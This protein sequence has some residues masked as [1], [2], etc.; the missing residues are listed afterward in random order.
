MPYK[1]LITGATGLIGRK[2]IKLLAGNG[3][4]ITAVTRNSIKARPLFPGNVKLIEWDYKSVSEELIHSIQECGAVIHLAGENVLSKRWNTNHKEKIYS[5]RVGSTRLIAELILKLN[6]KPE[7]FISASAVG[8]YGLKTELP[9]DETAPCGTD[10]LARLT[11][12]WEDATL[13]LEQAGIRCVKIRT[14]IVLDRN[15]GAFA[16]MILPFKFFAGGPL[17][18]GKQFFPWVH[19]EDIAGI[20]I[21]ALNNPLMS[22]V[23]NGAAPETI[24]MKDFCIIIGKRMKRPS[25]F[26]V[27][28]FALKALYGQGAEILLN[29]VNVIPRRT[30]ESGYKF[31]FVNSKEAVESLL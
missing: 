18:N 1:I 7:V 27:P 2:I 14:G 21:H 16:K 25:F 30:L 17:G 29:G 26:N 3:N 12:D 13:G 5:S 11:K 20:F 19:I 15:E 23:Y 24:T 8:Y 10:F 28:S 31:S 9:A 22:G 4:L 6:R